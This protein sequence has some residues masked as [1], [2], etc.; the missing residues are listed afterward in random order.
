[1]Q[2]CLL[3][4]LIQVCLFDME[5]QLPVQVRDE[6]MGINGQDELAD[7][8]QS[9]INKEYYWNQKREAI[10]HGSSN[11]QLAGGPIRGYT[12]ESHLSY[13]T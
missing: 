3:T 13:D 9:D 11:P 7:V 12:D 6:L 10:Q 5:Y 8:P 4:T 2:M 1:M